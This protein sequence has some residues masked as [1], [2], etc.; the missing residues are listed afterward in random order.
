MLPS[1]VEKCKC[2]GFQPDLTGPGRAEGKYS[3]KD[4]TSTDYFSEEIRKK[5]K[6]SIDR[7]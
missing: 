6:D 1:L 3:V 5:K 7:T 4:T 2:A